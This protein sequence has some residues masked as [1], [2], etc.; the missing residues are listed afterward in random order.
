MDP[1]FVA[2]PVWSDIG[3]LLMFLWV[4]L[5]LVIIFASNL[6]LAHVLIPSLIG[7]KHLPERLQKLRPPFYGVAILAFVGVVFVIIRVADLAHILE[8]VYPKW[9][10]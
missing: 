4:F 2:N 10:L 9:F 8:K 1:A 3:K 5:L 7:T 6:L